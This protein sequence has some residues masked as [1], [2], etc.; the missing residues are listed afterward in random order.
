MYDLFTAP[1]FKEIRLRDYQ[2]EAIEELR[3]GIRQ[4]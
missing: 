3:D 2:S 4:G 1:S